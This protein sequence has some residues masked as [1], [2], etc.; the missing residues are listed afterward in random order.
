[1]STV[2]QIKKY[3][4]HCPVLGISKKPNTKVPGSWENA[5]IVSCV[6][7]GLKLIILCWYDAGNVAAAT[8][9]NNLGPQDGPSRQVDL[10]PASTEG[11]AAKPQSQQSDYEMAVEFLREKKEINAAKLAAL[12]ES[13]TEQPILVGTDKFDAMPASNTAATVEAGLGGGM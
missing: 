10:Q 5:I 7:Y 11:G 3:M 1:M 9:I 13:A 6:H 2:Q 12:K 8:S 4:P